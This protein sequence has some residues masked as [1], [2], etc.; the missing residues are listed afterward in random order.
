MSR[1]RCSWTQLGD[2]QDLRHRSLSPSHRTGRWSSASSS[3]CG[4]TCTTRESTLASSSSLSTDLRPRVHCGSVSVRQIENLLAEG[5]HR[6]FHARVQLE[7]LDL[8]D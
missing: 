3:T 8:P 5:I 4:P 7:L 1:Q 6:C 2:N